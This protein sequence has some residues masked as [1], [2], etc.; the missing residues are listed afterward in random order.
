LSLK[1]NVRLLVHDIEQKHVL[2]TG[3][4]NARATITVARRTLTVWW[5]EKSWNPQ[6]IH[7]RLRPQFGL[8]FKAMPHVDIG[9]AM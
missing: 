7:L 4:S 9:L 5:D 6:N 3:V 8:K 1:I 2:Y